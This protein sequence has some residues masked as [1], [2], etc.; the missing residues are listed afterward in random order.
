MPLSTDP[1]KRR[2]QLQNLE[3]GAQ[4]AAQRH[5]ISARGA[6]F[7]GPGNPPIQETPP[8]P[9]AGLPVVGYGEPARPAIAAPAPPAERLHDQHIDVDE[10]VDELD[11]GDLDVG[12]LDV[13][14]DDV[15][16][17]DVDAG[18]RGGLGGLLDG[19]LGR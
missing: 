6:T 2:R 5:G 16:D 4:I 15:V 9:A 10:E 13:G 7:T 1:E 18:E 3:R 12:E 14:D 11:V 17:Q 19:F 8:A